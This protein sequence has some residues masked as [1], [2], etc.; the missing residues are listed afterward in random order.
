VEDREWRD[1]GVGRAKARRE[2]TTSDV[3]MRVKVGDEEK[4]KEEE[5]VGRGGR[6]EGRPRGLAMERAKKK[7]ARRRRR[8]GGGR[9]ESTTREGEGGGKKAK[10]A[11]G[12]EGCGLARSTGQAFLNLCPRIPP[13][14]GGADMRRSRLIAWRCAA[15]RGGALATCTR[16]PSRTRLAVASDSDATANTSARR[17]SGPRRDICVNVQERAWTRRASAR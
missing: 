7:N 15:V 4:K 5:V 6:T 1:I 2:R 14:P 17:S 16:R 13:P 3:R 11:K 8:G 12:A 10:D 9:R